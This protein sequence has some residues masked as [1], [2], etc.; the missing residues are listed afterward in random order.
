M[1]NNQ[2]PSAMWQSICDGI[3]E[4]R[5]VHKTRISILK[6]LETV[7]NEIIPDLLESEIAEF[8]GNAKKSGNPSEYLADCIMGW[9]IAAVKNPDMVY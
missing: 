8:K 9:V 3:A 2:K 4:E 7:Q 5:G 1:E 6:N